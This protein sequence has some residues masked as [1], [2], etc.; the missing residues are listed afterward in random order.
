[1]VFD[2]VKGYFLVFKVLGFD[3]CERDNQYWEDKLDRLISKC[4]GDIY[5]VLEI[6]YEEFSIE[7][8]NVFL[9]IV[10]FFR[11]EKVDYVK[12]FFNSYGVDVFSVI[13][14]LVDKC[15]IIFFDDCIEMYDMLQIMG[16][17]IS[18]KVEIIVIRGF[19]WLLLYGIQFQLYIRLW[20]S[21]YICYLLIKG[22]VMV[23]L[24]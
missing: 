2:Y 11:L 13:E 21:D 3:F 22:L 7:Q 24:N 4:Y 23:Y 16:K 8:K 18:L 15:L 17:E 10:C 20:D 9:D 14:D 5:E 1:M 6:S 19:R 12:S